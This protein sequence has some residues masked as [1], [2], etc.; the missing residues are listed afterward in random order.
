[1]LL[2]ISGKARRNLKNDVVA[3]ENMFFT[4]TYHEGK[5]NSKMRVSINFS[6]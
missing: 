3:L 5:R 1:M 4:V 6:F 2:M